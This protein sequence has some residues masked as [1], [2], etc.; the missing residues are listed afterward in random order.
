MY[1]T[2]LVF[3]VASSEC[4]SDTLPSPRNS[5]MWW[6]AITVGVLVDMDA[7]HL[8]WLMGAAEL[9]LE[10]EAAEAEAQWELERGLDEG[11][12]VGAVS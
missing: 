3:L 5:A 4:L 7:A 6:N 8:D 10:L 12:V 11:G 2:F 1:M 9:D